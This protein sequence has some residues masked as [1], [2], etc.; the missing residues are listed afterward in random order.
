M[1][2]GA[3]SVNAQ[4]T[5]K[6]EHNKEM[7]TMPNMSYCRFRNTRP[8]L[9]DCADHISDECNDPEEEKAR[10]DIIRICREIVEEIGNEE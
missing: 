5:P 9:Q 1:S 10:L 2:W 6:G 4:F 7:E 8:D 3:H